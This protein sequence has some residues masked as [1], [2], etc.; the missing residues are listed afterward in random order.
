MKKCIKCGINKEISEFVKTKNSCKECEKE[1]K[2]QYRLK[3]KE[4][5]KLKAKAY[6]ENNKDFLKEK[7]KENYE[8][9]KEKKIAYQKKYSEENKDK[10]KEYKSNYAQLNKCKIREYKN[11]YQ[12]KRRN[13]DPIFKLKYVISRSIRRSLKCKG[14][15]KDKKSIEILGCSIEF[16]KIY[17]EKLFNSEMSWENYGTIWDLDHVIP[18]STAITEE[19]VIKLNHYTN[20]QPL[21]SHINRNIKRDK[22]DFNLENYST[23]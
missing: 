23:N 11:N 9:N 6:Y 5:V 12:N 8:K 17:L 7:V 15:S 4:K 16:F 2:K 1:Y 3:N 21:D 22:I 18:L 20:L 10:I 14:I 19:D 13:E